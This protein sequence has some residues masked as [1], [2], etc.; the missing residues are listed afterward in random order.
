MLR[1]GVNLVAS[2]VVRRTFN[3]YHI[4]LMA[5]TL[6]LSCGPPYN[7]SAEPAHPS[8]TMLRLPQ[9]WS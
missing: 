8:V 4:Q 5:E 3:R 2:D 9:L 7:A 6:F 1:A